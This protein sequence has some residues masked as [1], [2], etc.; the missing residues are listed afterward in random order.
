MTFKKSS[1]YPLVGLALLLGVILLLTWHF[2][3]PATQVIQGEV[4]ARELNVSSKVAG[5]ISRIL[6]REGQAV[7][8]DELLAELELPEIEAKLA[9]AAAARAAAR[10]QQDKADHGARHEEI[11][12]AR[13]LWLEAAAASQLLEK[14]YRRLQVLYEDGVVPA[15]RR[16]EAE[17]KWKASVHQTQAGPVGL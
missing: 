17:A 15:Q 14:T 3:E 9:Q 2:Q 8:Q 4:E 7:N 5:R 11:T 6:V 1:F 13:N 16:D 10:A 12:A